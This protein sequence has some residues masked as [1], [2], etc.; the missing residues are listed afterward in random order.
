MTTTRVKY[1]TPVVKLALERNW[2]SEQQLKE[3]KELLRKSTRIGLESTIEEI[4]VKQGLLSQQQLDELTELSDL[5]EK[6]SLFG[7]YRLG[8]MLGKGG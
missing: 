5:A 2:I 6:G 3:C 8:E 4:L 1:T 7:A